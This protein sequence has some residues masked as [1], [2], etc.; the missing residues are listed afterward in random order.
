MKYTQKEISQIF[1][2]LDVVKWDFMPLNQ[3]K[4]KFYNKKNEKVAEGT[5]KIILSS[6]PGDT[7]TFAWD[8][9]SYTSFPVID[10]SCIASYKRVTPTSNE[11]AY[12][13]ALEIATESDADFIYQA[14][15]MYLAVFNFKRL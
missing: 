14:M 4:I 9:F 10:K 15:R 8:I 2:E 5:F 11:E 12:L 7:Y 3:G 1:Q 6:A 13:K